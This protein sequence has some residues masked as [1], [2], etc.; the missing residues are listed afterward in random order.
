MISLYTQRVLGVGMGELFVFVESG[1]GPWF[2]VRCGLRL[3]LRNVRSE[4]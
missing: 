3:A 2:C 1:N 4:H